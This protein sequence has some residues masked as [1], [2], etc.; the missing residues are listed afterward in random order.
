MPPLLHHPLGDT[1]AQVELHHGTQIDVVVGIEAHLAHIHNLV[2]PLL[3]LDGLAALPGLVGDALGHEAVM[4]AR[5][6][7]L[8]RV[9]R[10]HGH[11]GHEHAHEVGHGVARAI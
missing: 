11:I 8:E 1:A 2:G 6:A 5:E 10:R 7:S 9:E 4:S 3:A